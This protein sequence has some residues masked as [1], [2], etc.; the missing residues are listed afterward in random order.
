MKKRS[1][2]IALTAFASLAALAGC[3]KPVTPKDGYLLSMSGKDGETV[4]ISA[5]EFFNKYLKTKAG[6]KV[7]MMRFMK[8]LSANFE[9]KLVTSALNFMKKRSKKLPALK[10]MPEKC[11]G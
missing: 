9:S 5:E 4:S 7:T 11:N 1:I 3:S 6:I 10:K 8:S 2:T